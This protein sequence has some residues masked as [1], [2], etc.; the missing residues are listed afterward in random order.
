MIEI[1]GYIELDT[2][3]LPMLHENAIKL[4]CGR[5]AL[6]YLIESKNIKKL[7]IPKF[8]C[9]CITDLC[10]RMNIDIDTYSIDKSFRPIFNK[11]LNAGECFYLIN[12]YGQISNTEI[13]VYKGKYKNIIVDNAQAYFQ[14]PVE[15]IDTLYTC[16]KFF[17]VSDGAILYTDKK[18][19]RKLDIDESFNRMRFV[20]GRF[21]RSAREFYIESSENN[22]LFDNE[23]I[24]YMSKLTQNLL[25][26]IDYGYVGKKRTTNFEY[27]DKIFKDK[28]QLQLC[29]PNGAFMYPLLVSNGAEIRK[30]LQQK[31]IYI[32]VL[33]PNVLNECSEESIE[34]NFAKN[35]LP[36][37]CDQRYSE[38]EMEYMSKLILERMV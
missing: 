14:M 33:W 9:D 15:G 34:Y 7:Y 16:R 10:K 24:K 27:L 4:N 26:G 32:P 8:N 2:Y 13:E 12:Y 6:A 5:N 1:G 21:E 25:H 35:I 3:R 31:K 20:L 17:G 23:S 28:N 19:N 30:E 11:E 37:P 38:E 22:D 18:L 36:L 29:T